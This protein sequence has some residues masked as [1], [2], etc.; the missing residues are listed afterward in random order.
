MGSI[1]V[2]CAMIIAAV[3]FAGAPAWAQQG[4]AATPGTQ[5]FNVVLVLGDLQGG[6]A[7]DNIPAAARAALSDLKDFLPY[8]GY[9]VLDTAWILGST[10]QLF[11]AKSRLRGADDQTYEVSLTS[12]PTGPPAP[13]SLQMKFVMQDLTGGDPV[14]TTEAAHKEA[15][16]RAELL[17]LTAARAALEKS[18]QSSSDPSESPDERRQ[19]QAS[20]RERM[21]ELTI[22]IDTLQSQ[23]QSM[24]VGQ[25]L[26]DTSFNMRLGET[27]V[28]GTSRVRGDKALIALLT[29]VR[30]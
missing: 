29:A 10:T 8:K 27:V 18:A 12:S 17:Q 30:K 4:P 21:R 19:R 22:V 20:V 24:T 25:T 28:V 16:A 15:Q 14:R 9:R 23:L 13:P 26:I 5:G 11:R 1:R 6:A 2:R 3:L 7:P